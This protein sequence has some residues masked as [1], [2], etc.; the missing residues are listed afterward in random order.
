MLLPKLKE[1]FLKALLCCC[2][3]NNAHEVTVTLAF[4]LSPPKSA[5]FI[6]YFRRTFVSNLKKFINGISVIMP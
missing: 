1:N 4:N 3:H 5:K 6:F 2:V